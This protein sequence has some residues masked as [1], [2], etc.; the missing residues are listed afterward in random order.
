MGFVRSTGP[1]VYDFGPLS[2]QRM[3][4]P[5]DDLGSGPEGDRFNRFVVFVDFGILAP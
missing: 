4:V 1:P 2:T 5:H 3:D